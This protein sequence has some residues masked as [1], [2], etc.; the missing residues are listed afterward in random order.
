[1]IKRPFLTRFKNAFK[2]F[3][4]F[5]HAVPLYIHCKDYVKSSFSGFASIVIMFLILY[6]FIS[7]LKIW[8]ES[9]NVTT[10]SSSLSYSIEDYLSGAHTEM[11]N[12]TNQNYYVYFALFAFPPNSPILDY[13]NLT[14]F[15]SQKVT[16]YSPEG[17]MNDLEIKR[18]TENEYNKFLNPDA[19]M[20]IDNSE[21][22]F[23]S[24]LKDYNILMGLEPQQQ[25]K[26]LVPTTL[27]YQT[28]RCQ[29][30]T[31]NN[32]SCAANEELDEILPYVA[33][34]VTIPRSVYDFKNVQNPRK[35][36][37][38]IF[39]YSLDSTLT[40]VID[41][42]I[43]PVSVYGDKGYF[44]EDYYLKTTDFNIDYQQNDFIRDKNILFSQNIK[45][46]LKEQK[47]FQKNDSLLNIIA[48]LGGTINILF[49]I[50]KIICSTY[51]LMIL[52]HKLI[53]HSFLNLEEENV[54]S[55][56]K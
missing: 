20:S 9:G 56:K 45:F 55:R 31:E 51:N 38:D 18:C 7:A 8:A 33:V 12:L 52:K 11:F 42:Y 49:L 44:S 46:A 26:S 48:N 15:F 17:T 27:T 37:H 50:G 1:M 32:F 28:I 54:K 40:K 41:T 5:G 53:K 35:R 13:V 34:Q 4:L 10:I 47:Y 43:T 21:I 22:T 29:N 30:S 16:Y 23:T 6:S 3:D 25:M 19:P 14:R 39:G 36:L 2:F 24:C